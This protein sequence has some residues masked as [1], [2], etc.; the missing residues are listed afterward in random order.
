MIYYG[1][2]RT[3]EPSTLEGKLELLRFLDPG[4]SSLK[5]KIQTDDKRTKYFEK[6]LLSVYSCIHIFKKQLTILAAKV[7]KIWGMKPRA[8]NLVIP[9]VDII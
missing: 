5:K 2:K 9:L 7:N 4:V 6:I 1:I 8:D 3:S